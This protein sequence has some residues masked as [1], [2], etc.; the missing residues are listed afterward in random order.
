MSAISTEITFCT[1]LR[2]ASDFTCDFVGG[3]NALVGGL[4]TVLAA[5]LATAFLAGLAGALTGRL[6]MAIT[7]SLH[8]ARNEQD[9]EH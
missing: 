9:E 3:W 1:F 2:S 6:A 4:P 8:D 5:G 7:R